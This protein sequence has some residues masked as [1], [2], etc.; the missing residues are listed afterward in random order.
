[1]SNPWEDFAPQETVETPP[2]EDYTPKIEV[3][4]QPEEG[5]LSRIGGD[6]SKRWSPTVMGQDY[7]SIPAEQALRITGKIA[8]TG[9][10]IAGQTLKSAYKTLMP[11]V[12]QGGVS[13]AGN[14]IMNLPISEEPN[15]PTLK[16]TI[17]NAANVY[18]QLEQ[19]FP[20]AMK[21]INAVGNI[22][23]ILPVGKIIKEG[24][25]LGKGLVSE[26]GAIARD[27][28]KTMNATLP[29]TTKEFID[30]RI[31]Q[32]VKENINK[33]VRTSSAGKTSIPLLEKYFERSGT[34][35]KDIIDN[36]PNLSITNK[37]GETV[38]GVLP[39][40]RFQAAQASDNTKKLLFKE[41]ND[42]QLRAGE[43]GSM[44][45]LEPIAKELDA[46]ISN[47][48]LQAD[49]TG[50]SVI[51]YA[52]EQQVIL[53][54]MKDGLT[55]QQAQDWIS[56]ANA[57]FETAYRKGTYEEASKAG[58]DMGIA[59]MM[60]KK[61]DALIESTEGKGYQD[62]KLRYGAQKEFGEGVTKA[63]FA[64]LGEKNIPNFFDITSGAALA[65]GLLTLNP[66]TILTAGF[67]ES[68]NLLRRKFTNPDTYI[69][70]MFTDS[71]KIMSQTSKYKS[72]LYQS[73]E[74][75]P[76][77]ILPT[78][79]EEIYLKGLRNAKRYK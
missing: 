44:L 20:N 13:S 59:S 73:F 36:K 7:S 68:M 16:T 76:E 15:A 21:D 71:E 70:K 35:V 64:S 41:F 4:A 12:V 48:A 79:N 33:A 52:E 39:E 26:T 1:M 43:K 38:N 25:G 62:F 45:S 9:L 5:L 23:S 78:T 19:K 69:K 61:L 42:M 40:T 37:I 58:T 72:K 65:H 11:D 55:P 46:V 30:Q 47:P 67:M 57:K 17:G 56:N 24:V 54:K 22:A 6:I 18:G 49:K 53:R 74:K 28:I 3:S 29:E 2:W 60:R 14:A 75:P 66:V 32:V 10:D 31:N 27:T 51:A 8:G 50:R 34:A 77:T 63:G